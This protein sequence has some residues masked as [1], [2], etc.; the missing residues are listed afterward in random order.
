[1]PVRPTIDDSLTLEEAF[2]KLANLRGGAYYYSWKADELTRPFAEHATWEYLVE[3]GEEEYRPLVFR[4]AVIEKQRLACNARG[5]PNAAPYQPIVTGKEISEMVVESLGLEPNT[6]RS[7]GAGASS[8][9]A[10]D[11]NVEDIAEE[12][13]LSVEDPVYGEATV[14]THAGLVKECLFNADR[15]LTATE[16]A[17]ETD[18]TLTLTQKALSDLSDNDPEVVV[19]RKLYGEP[20]FGFAMN[21]GPG[22][23][24]EEEA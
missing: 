3:H 11:A 19:T 13:D 9:E 24:A 6:G 14:D 16:V 21:D 18:G 20:L 12:L 15:D 7:I 2:E 5:I 22:A 10:H 17:E 1:M 23:G 4:T 8:D